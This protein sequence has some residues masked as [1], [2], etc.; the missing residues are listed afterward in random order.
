MR[1]GLKGPSGKLPPDNTKISANDRF[2]MFQS[3]ISFLSFLDGNE[4][5]TTRDLA[6]SGLDFIRAS[7]THVYHD[8]P[9]AEEPKP[10][11]LVRPMGHDQWTQAFPFH[12]D[13]E[14]LCCH[15]IGHAQNL[16][17]HF[18]RRNGT[19]GQDNGLISLQHRS[20]GNRGIQ[21]SQN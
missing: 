16:W 3:F 2:N 18:Q 4:T 6:M 15:H 21:A 12:S 14:G 13:G 11:D 19:R 5:R 9:C 8:I 1:N 7:L 17:I 20:D 10:R